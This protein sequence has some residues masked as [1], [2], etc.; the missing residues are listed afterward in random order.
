MPNFP[1]HSYGMNELAGMLMQALYKK[2]D[3]NKQN[4]W[5]QEDAARQNTWN[6]INMAMQG[7]S[8]ELQFTPDQQ[9]ML[10]DQAGQINAMLKN[11]QETM[12]TEQRATN[13]LRQLQIANQVNSGIVDML[14]VSKDRTISP[15]VKR[16][17][18][19]FMGKAAQ[20][21]GIDIGLTPLDGW[22]DV[23]DKWHKGLEEKFLGANSNVTKFTS[24]PS[25]DS[26]MSALKDIDA[27]EE[28]TGGNY[29]SVRMGI[30]SVWTENK[31]RSAEIE[32]QRDALSRYT[33]PQVLDDTR[34]FYLAKADLLKNDMG[35][36]PAEN[37]EEYNNLMQQMQSDMVMARKGQ[38]P[39][40]QL[41][42]T[43]G[44][45]MKRPITG[46]GDMAMPGYQTTQN[47]PLTKEDVDALKIEFK[48]DMQAA[49]AAARDRGY[50][51][52][53]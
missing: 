21:I 28:M 53:E 15:E 17:M 14:K 27:L 44:R 26:Y 40:W 5:Q 43:R 51:F 48:G 9:A 4:L 12:E 37:R 30:N 41:P 39:T 20:T 8:G 46:Q 19:G 42:E 22:Q 50:I 24:K 23:Q 34:S 7:G 16:N 10:G 2:Q 38:T 11:R 36:V 18:L 29:E 45:E 6:Q 33:V 1:V 52:T 49:M 31:N 3:L 35:F 13:Q 25:N 47:K 32:K